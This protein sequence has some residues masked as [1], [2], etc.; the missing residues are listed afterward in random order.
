M[1]TTWRALAALMSL[2]F[3]SAAWAASGGTSG[4]TND[5][6][7]YEAQ[8][9]GLLEADNF[10]ALE[11]MANDARASKARFPGGIWKLFAFYVGINLKFQNVAVHD[12]LWEAQLKKIEQWSKKKPKSITARVALALTHLE[13]GQQIRGQGYADSIEPAAMARY[14]EQ[15]RTAHKVLDD[16]A[17]LS[18]KCPEWFAAMQQVALNEGWDKVRAEKLLASAVAQEP[19][20]YHVYRYHANYLR[21]QWYGEEGEVEAWADTVRTTVGG[22]YGAFLYFE[23]ASL[24]N[25][26]CQMT[27]PYLKRMSWPEIKAGYAALKSLYGDNKLKRNRFA[28]MATKA[29][30]NEAARRAFGEIGNDWDDSVWGNWDFFRVSRES[31][32]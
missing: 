26:G 5:M 28:Y 2:C 8:V 13:W 21:P 31:V 30:D 25:C 14:Q 3:F 16:A 20:Y 12:L 24:L 18:E 7:R 9:S 10:D 22:S 23:I 6:A 19:E 17:K 32:K 15:V 29:G 11:K 4:G 27:E 1:I